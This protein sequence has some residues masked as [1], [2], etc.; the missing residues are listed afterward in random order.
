MTQIRNLSLSPFN[1]LGV[2]LGG[3]WMTEVKLRSALIRL[4]DSN[5][6]V[7]RGAIRELEKLGVDLPKVLLA[8]YRKSGAWRA[9]VSCV[10]FAV[11]YARTSDDAVQ[12]GIE[13]LKD[14]SRIVRYR[15]CSL[16]A[17]SFR[18]NALPYLRAL[19]NHSDSSTVEDACA[20]IDCIEHKNHHWFMDRGHTGR[21]EWAVDEEYEK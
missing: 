19:L 6:D 16:L 20:G 18:D 9:R 12:L 2:L 5:P 14:R 13:A 7:N 3:S 8:H 4:G 10:F 17:Y 11:P 21:L 1:D 15:A